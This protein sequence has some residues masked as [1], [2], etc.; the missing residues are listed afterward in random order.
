[1][2]LKKQ[3]KCIKSMLGFVGS[4]QFY[5]YHKIG[6]LD[7]LFVYLF[8]I[9]AMLHCFIL[10]VHLDTLHNGPSPVPVSTEPETY[11][12]LVFI[13]II[14]MGHGTLDTLKNYLTVTKL[15]FTPSYN[16]TTV[17]D[18][19][20]NILGPCAL[21]KQLHC[22]WHICDPNFDRQWKLRHTFD[23]LLDVHT[24]FYSASGHLTVCKVT[25]VCKV[26]E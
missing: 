13:I 24:K 16:K 7:I 20:L 21:F 6:V 19:F 5:N 26:E 25:V 4:L 2:I 3:G 17:S 23:M 1:M 10:R 12:F 14:K 11:I 9:G 15:F 22:Y 8:V 18:T